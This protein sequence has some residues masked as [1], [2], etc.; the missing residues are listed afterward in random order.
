[1]TDE[2]CIW[3]R[4]AKRQQFHDLFSKKQFESPIVDQEL[5]V[6]S[7]IGPQL[8]I[9]PLSEP[10]STDF[11]E[12]SNFTGLCASATI[13]DHIHFGRC[14]ECVTAINMGEKIVQVKAFASVNDSTDIAYCL[15]CHSLTATAHFIACDNCP[16]VAFCCQE[17]KINNQSHE[18]ECQTI[19]HS[20]T[21]GVN[22][23]IKCAI[24]MIFEFL[25]LFED[26]V[27]MMMCTVEEMAMDVNDIDEISVQFNAT[28]RNVNDNLSKFCCILNLK[29]DQYD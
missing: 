9:K 23:N 22:L 19:F 21:F 5:S 28:P 15:T 10:F 7:R 24:Q 26:D 16:S 1:M 25:V 8:E 29:P 27:D 18:Y 2:I 13:T 17:C 4:P 14:I 12:N 20:T 6:I 11:R 3:C